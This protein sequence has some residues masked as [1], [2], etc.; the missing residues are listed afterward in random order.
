MSLRTQRPLELENSHITDLRQPR[1]GTASLHGSQTLGVLG[2][3]GR[4][5]ALPDP[6]LLLHLPVL[7]SSGSKGGLRDLDLDLKDLE[8][9]DKIVRGFRKAIK[10]RLLILS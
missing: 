8:I 7:V 10:G 6:G 5:Q 3:T 9:K 1:R 4:L 2:S